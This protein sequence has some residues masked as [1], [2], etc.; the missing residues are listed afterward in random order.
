MP[1]YSPPPRHAV[2]PLPASSS[3]KA[4]T[5]APRARGGNLGAG[6]H[7]AGGPLDG[8]RS[9]N[10]DYAW[11]TTLRRAPSLSLDDQ[12]ADDVRAKAADAVKWLGTK[13]GLAAHADRRDSNYELVGRARP[14]SRDETPS[15]RFA[16]MD[17][18]VSSCLPRTP[19]P[20]VTCAFAAACSHL[21]SCAPALELKSLT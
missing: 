14:E 5:S 13:V 8:E 6:T 15:E 12:A 19:S 9:P 7:G 3:V 1:P 18:A 11:S 20:S 17:V 21:L 10:D 4:S 16:K 2:L